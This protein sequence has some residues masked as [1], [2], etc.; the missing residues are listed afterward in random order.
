MIKTKVK[1][2]KIVSLNRYLGVTGNP[3]LADLAQFKIKKNS[4]TGNT[5]LL[6]FNGNNQCNPLPTNVLVRF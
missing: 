4:K 3:G 2:R 5:E 1:A 6:F